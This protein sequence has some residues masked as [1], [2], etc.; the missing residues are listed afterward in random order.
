[1]N[2]T[3]TPAPSGCV[4]SWDDPVTGARAHLWCPDTTTA[5]AHATEL[6]ATYD[7]PTEAP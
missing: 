1:M 3:I 6:R 5:E 4:L 2:P 7:L